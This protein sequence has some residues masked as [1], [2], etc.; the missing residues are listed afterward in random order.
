M[1]THEC[2][3]AGDGG[4]G[5]FDGVF[6]TGNGQ[7]GGLDLDKGAEKRAGAAERGLRNGRER[8]HG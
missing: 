4:E 1:K 5:F 3:H 2:L 8:F 7:A 6:E